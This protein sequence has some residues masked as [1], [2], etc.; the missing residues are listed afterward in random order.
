MKQITRIKNVCRL[1]IAM[2]GYMGFS[3]QGN[4]EKWAKNITTFSNGDESITITENRNTNVLKLS[5]S[6]SAEKYEILEL[7]NHEAAHR[8][9]K[10]NTDD[11]EKLHKG[12]RGDY[13]FTG[14]N[15]DSVSAPVLRGSRGRRDS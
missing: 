10:T 11:S 1:L 5:K 8:S 7:S 13:T 6:E 15:K 2:L 12:E 4:G 14:H 9:S 3:Q